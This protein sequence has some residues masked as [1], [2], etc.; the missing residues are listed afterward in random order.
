VNAANT[1]QI[2]GFTLASLENNETQAEKEIPQGWGSQ[3]FSQYSFSLPRYFAVFMNAAPNGEKSPLFSDANIRKAF[4][5]AV[6]TK[7]LINQIITATKTPVNEVTSPILPDFYKYAQPTSPYQFN[8]DQAKSLL[9][10]A[11]F[12]DDG[13]GQRQKVTTKKP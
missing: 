4:S 10:K 11:G 7:D 12:K 9:D 2:E 8:P 1:K 3:R 5:Y 6:D 13:S